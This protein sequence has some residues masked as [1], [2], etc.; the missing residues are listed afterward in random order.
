[1]RPP[2]LPFG[3]RARTGA[4]AALLALPLLAGCQPEVVKITG[5]TMGSHYQISYVRAGKA[6]APEV[7]KA[8]VEKILAELDRDVSTYRD[9]SAVARFNAAPAGTCMAMPGNALTL[10][11]FANQLRRGSEDA[12]DITMLPVL[13]AWGFGPKAA[14]QQPSQGE[15]T[16][17]ALQQSPETP[18]VPSQQT[19]TELR[20]QVGQQHL[21]IRGQ[22]LCK[23]A[24]VQIDFNSIAAGLAIDAIGNALGAQG[25]E[26]YLIDVTGEIKGQGKKPDGSPW[27]V[28]IEAPVDNARQIQRIIALNGQTISTSGDYRQYREVA[29]QRLSHVID[30]RTLTPITHRLAAVTVVH[31]LGVLSDGYSTLLMV[32]GPEAGYRYARDKG[33]A[34]LFVT[35]EGEGFQSRSTPEFDRMFPKPR[36]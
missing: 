22:E 3:P 8:E 36:S 10:A 1:M 23:Q 32:L 17:E 11:G 13:D 29:G 25:I 21:S 5:P 20:A 9:D 26:N 16:V 4:L 35:R 34:A 2:S 24:P 27:R 30:P 6:P 15:L 7:V 28:A 31:P 33:L 18:P 12:Y 19:L 14:R